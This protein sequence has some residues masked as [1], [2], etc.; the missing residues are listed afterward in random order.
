MGKVRFCEMSSPPEKRHTVSL[1]APLARRKKLWRRGGVRW[2]WRNNEATT[3]PS[4]APAEK[5]MSPEDDL[6]TFRD[7]FERILAQTYHGNS[8]ITDTFISNDMKG[9]C[10][11]ENSMDET[12]FGCW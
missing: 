4:N 10:H 1:P 8:F 5:I 9:A 11:V 2:F 7:Q 6:R 12:A 3:P